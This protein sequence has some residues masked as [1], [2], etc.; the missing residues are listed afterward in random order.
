MLLI[1]EGVTQGDPLLVVLYCITL[2][3][4]SEELRAADPGLLSRFYADDAT[5]DVSARRSVK[6]LKVFMEIGLYKGY[7]PNPANPFFIDD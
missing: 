5:F 1:W 2:V 3:L 6:I 7:F 4:L